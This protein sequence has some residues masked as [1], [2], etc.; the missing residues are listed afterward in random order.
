MSLSNPNLTERSHAALENSVLQGA[1]KAATTTFIERRRDAIT[2]VADW[3]ALR[4]RARQVKEHTINNLD[5]YLE[6]VVENVEA[7][8]GKVFWAR[9]GDDVSR[10]IIELARA[11]GVKSVV[12]SKSMATE[13]IELNH[14]LEAAGVRPVETD[15]GEYIIQLAHEKPSHIIVPAI[16]K[17]RSQISDLFEEKLREGRPNEVAEITAM[18]RKRLRNEFLSAGMGITGANFLIAESGTV[19]LVENEGNIRL[20]TQVPK[21]H[22]AVVGIE[23][24]VP[25]FDDLSVFLRLLPRSG[26]GQ[27][28]TAYV[29]F[30]NGPRQLESGFEFHLVLMDNGRTRILADEQMRESLYCIRCGACLNV[31]PVYQKIGGQAYGWIYPGPIGAVISPQL[32]SLGQ[33]GDLPFASSLCGACRTA[34][35]VDINLPDLLLALRAKAKESG[36]GGKLSESL[37]MRSVAFAAKHPRLFELGGKVMRGIAR[38]MSKDEKIKDVGFPPLSGWTRYRDLPAPPRGSFRERWK[39]NRHE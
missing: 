34:C 21:I 27:K 29:S 39:R 15:L 31:C 32:Q 1:L 4:Q 33:S 38:L 19:V 7:L 11:R 13:E 23:K 26:T 37:A 14:A 36:A 24:V 10:Y 6:Q 8:G 20:S 2:S 28:Q 12:K 22:V 9:T 18:A 25:R 30:L 17:T 3:E 16:H 35:P 5:Y